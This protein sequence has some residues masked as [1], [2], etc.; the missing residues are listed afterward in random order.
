M[1]GEKFDIFQFDK[2]VTFVWPDYW[3]NGPAIQ[4]KILLYQFLL[5]N[6][7]KLVNAII[8]IYIFES[9]GLSYY[10]ENLDRCFILC[11]WFSSTLQ[12]MRL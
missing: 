10:F 8:Y 9:N 7:N 11:D 6:N 2:E 4:Q 3:W 5:Q 1:E 12:Q